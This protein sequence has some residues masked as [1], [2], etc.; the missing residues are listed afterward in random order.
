MVAEM[1]LEWT[2]LLAG[3]L[4]LAVLPAAAQSRKAPNVVLVITD[5]Q[6]Y[7]DLGFHGNPRVHTPHLDQLARES[8]R[9]RSFY[10]SPVC[11]PTRASLMTGRYHYRTGVVDTYLGRSLM[12]P[13]EVTLAELLRAAGYRTGIFGKWHLGDNYPMRAMDQGFD[14]SLVLNGGGIG[15][16]SDPPGGESY[17]DPVLRRNGQWAKTRGYVSDVITDA[18]IAFIDANRG[19]PFFAYLAFNAPHTPLEVPENLYEKYRQMRLAAKEFPSAGHPIPEGFDPETTARVYGMVENIDI[20]VGRLLASLDRLQLARDTVFVFLT[21]NGP[22]QPRYNAGMLDRKGST[23]EGGIRVPFFVRWPGRLAPGREVDRVAAHIDVAPTL[24]DLCGVARPDGVRLDGMSLRSLLEGDGAAWP[25][26]TLFFQ[27]H[28]GDAPQ[29]YRA[30]AARTQRYKLVQPAGADDARRGWTPAFELYDMSSDPLETTD[31]ASARPDLVTRMKADH[32]AWFEDVTR[33]IARPRI[34]IGAPQEN[35]VRLTR[36]DWRGPQ[37][38]WT[39]GSIGHWEIDVVRAGQYQ[40]TVRFAPPAR[41][42]L[43]ACALGGAK[44]QKQVAAG[45]A[46][47]VFD[48]VRLAKGSGVLE[49]EVASGG[50]TAG[51]LDAL[52]SRRDP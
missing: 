4:L 30:F 37:A 35:P 15:Q 34:A 47:V 10:V 6:G 5:D 25:D 49:C 19:G 46:S 14:E 27:W 2:G 24:L 33:D 3:M 9:L 36:Q 31:I 13:D 41:A 39:P 23:H 48:N 28:R 18:A 12:R 32:D 44:R 22:Q 29:K 21:D 52:V 20:N 50:S 7:G 38:G 42:G 1:R 8:V 51:V 26:R 17:F 40:V 16:P 45:T 43:V 11:S